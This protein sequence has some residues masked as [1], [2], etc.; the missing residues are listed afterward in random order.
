[1]FFIEISRSRASPLSRKRR[2]S[3]DPTRGY[4]VEGEELLIEI[5]TYVGSGWDYKE[6]RFKM[7]GDDLH[8]I[9]GEKWDT[10]KRWDFP[11]EIYRKMYVGDLRSEPN[12]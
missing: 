11:Q 12:W 2:A 4:I 6:M 3:T 10:P 5:Y 1:M 9:P 8:R 7:K